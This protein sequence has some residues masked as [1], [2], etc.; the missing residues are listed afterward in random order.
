MENM[1]FSGRGEGFV[2]TFGIWWYGSR[3]VGDDKKTA[4]TLI[5]ENQDNRHAQIMK[6]IIM[7][8]MTTRLLTC[9]ERATYF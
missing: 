1:T 9:R 2:Q 5:I 8:S 3:C 6:I 7:M 4:N